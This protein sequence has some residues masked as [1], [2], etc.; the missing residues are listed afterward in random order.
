MTMEQP[1][2]LRGERVLLRQPAEQDHTDYMRVD[3]DPEMLHMYGEDRH[4]RLLKTEADAAAFLEAISRHPHEWCVEYEGRLIGQAR[5]TVR[6]EDEKA[7]FAIGLFDPS[8]WGQGLGTEITKLVLG[9]AFETLRLHRVELKVLAYNTRAIRCYEKSGFIKEG[10]EREG[11]LVEG[12]FHDDIR[13]SILRKEF[14]DR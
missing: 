14:E 6:W 5:L 12:T 9:Y 3:F 1:P 4:R 7:R 8:V 13:M 10:I 2:E 11:A